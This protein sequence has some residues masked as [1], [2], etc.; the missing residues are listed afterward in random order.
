MRPAR[1]SA[2]CSLPYSPH[3]GPS[4]G[5]PPAVL[6]PSALLGINQHSF[7]PPRH[8]SAFLQPSLASVLIHSALL[9]IIQQFLQ[10]SLASVIHSALL[11]I[12]QQFLQPS[13]A[14][15]S[16]PPALL[17]ISPH[18][19]S[20]PVG[21]IQQFLQPP[22]A[23]FSIPS[24]LQLAPFSSSFS[25]L[26]HLSAFL[27]PWQHS[28]FLQP[29]SWH[30]SSFSPQHQS[31]L[32]YPSSASV[33][34]QSALIGFSPFFSLHPSASPVPKNQHV[35]P[36]F[37]TTFPLPLAWSVKPPNGGVWYCIPVIRASVLQILLPP[38]PALLQSRS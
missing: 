17:G 18:S 29:F 23:S 10:P 7:S 35:Y 19:F 24:A 4:P 20:P 1:V 28:T 16:I 12:I 22:L 11:G 34:I 25:P 26:W 14:S 8:H 32:S 9:G 36:S 5:P 30:Q 3:L 6:I 37:P 38:L 21:I 15:F 13:L 31:A 33:L 2:A 27:Q